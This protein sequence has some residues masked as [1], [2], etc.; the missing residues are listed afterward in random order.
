MSKLKEAFDK[1]RSDRPQPPRY[2]TAEDWVVYWFGEPMDI[3]SPAIPVLCKVISV[4]P[5]TGTINGWGFLDPTMEFRDPQGRPVQA[6]PMV[7]VCHSPYS[8]QP[9]KKCWT[10]LEGM[11]QSQLGI[12]LDGDPDEEPLDSALFEVSLAPT[13]TGEEPEE[14]GSPA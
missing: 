1:Q 8:A 14:E 10:F 6:P 12:K 11:E 3:G 7:P 4:Q 5:D 13:L 9:R 2:P